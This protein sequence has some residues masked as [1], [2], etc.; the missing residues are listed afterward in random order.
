MF[1]MVS[2][3]PHVKPATISDFAS[4]IAAL[5]QKLAGGTATQPLVYHYTNAQGFLGI[6]ESQEIWATHIA[7]TNDSAE[8]IEATAEINNQAKSRI[9]S[10]LEASP[11]RRALQATIERTTIVSPDQIP[12]WFIA[13]F[14]YGVDDLS[15]WRGYGGK[16]GKFAIGLNLNH[17]GAIARAINQ[18]VDLNGRLTHKC[19]LLPAVYEKPKKQSLAFDVLNFIVSKYPDSE[20]EVSPRDLDAYAKAW[21]SDYLYFAAVL[22]P[23]AKH[24]SFSSEREWRLVIT[25]SSHDHVSYRPMAST[26]APFVRIKLLAASFSENNGPN[27]SHPIREVWVGPTQHAELSLISAKSILEKFKFFGVDI[28]RSTVPFRDL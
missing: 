5:I 27:Y 19:Y 21:V 18:S 22:A 15:Q 12:P 11:E 1:E 20:K 17:L 8:Y 2:G 25:T 9:S 13:S 23:S 28:K 3:F 16:N 26:L 4:N 7:F 24:D 6:V 10:F 14:S